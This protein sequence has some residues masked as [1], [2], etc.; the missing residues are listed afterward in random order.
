MKTLEIGTFVP[1]MQPVVGTTQEVIQAHGTTFADVKYDGYRVQ[2][3][4][5]SKVK[6]FTR[7]GQ[8]LNYACYPDIVS[9]VKHMPEGIFD[10]EMVGEGNSSKETFHHVQQRFRKPDMGVESVER[11]IAS[12]IIQEVPLSLRLFDVLQFEKKNA[13]PLALSERRTLVERISEKGIEP[14]ETQ[15]VGSVEEL[16]NVLA[17]TFMQGKEGRVCK[18]PASVYRSG[19]HGLD[20]I[21]LKRSEPLD[22]V[23]V[24][25]YETKLCENGLPFTAVLGATYNDRTGL[26]EPLSKVVVTKKGFADELNK[27]IRPYLSKERPG[28]VVFSERLGQKSYASKVP[29][30]FID[31]EKSVVL[32]VSA[33]NINFVDTWHSCGREGN[34]AYSLRMAAP[35]QVRYD[36]TPKQATS[37]SSIAKLYKLQ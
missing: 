19:K 16:E 31:P 5:N 25:T 14:A 35:V 9:L 37:T 30:Q 2:V 7:S 34:K 32:E 24:G 27:A 21:K 29:T 28:S 26:Y 22:L 13:I 36:K 15:Q 18:D 17:A 10:A 4:R 3:H 1:T 33:L 6:L 8:E 20:W 23:V 11:Y 12:G